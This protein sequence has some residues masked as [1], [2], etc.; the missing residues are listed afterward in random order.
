MKRPN[1][2]Q[3]IKT[4]TASLAGLLGATF[5]KQGRGQALKSK[6]V[7]VTDGKA[8]TG[9][10]WDNQALEQQV[11]TNML[12]R[13][14]INL[15]SAKDSMTALKSLIPNLSSSSRIAI[16]VNC[17]N[18][19]LPSQPKVVL[20]L[21]DLLAEAGA[22]INNIVIYDR[23]DAELVACGYKLNT[24]SEG[25]KCYSSQNKA[26]GYDDLLTR[27]SGAE[28]RLSKITSQQAEHIINVAVL[29]NH[30][31]AGVSL[32]LKN[33]FGSID[34]PEYL[35]GSDRNCSPEIARL[36]ANQ[37]IHGKTRLVLIDAMF[38]TYK[39]G[40]AAKPDFAPMTLIAA[41]DP[42]AAD[43]VGQEMINLRR[44]QDKLEPII[45]EHIVA[46]Q[47]LG[48]GTGQSSQIDKIELRLDPVTEKPKPWLKESSGCQTI[49]G[50]NQ[51]LV[52]TAAALGAIKARYNPRNL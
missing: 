34:R 18:S 2:R 39:S 45:A 3:F 42:V 44:Q 51:N 8:W 1:R 33:H 48:L 24:S 32:T 17:V 27:V 4:L 25:I 47:K 49:E 23:S 38:A 5:F 29:K 43:S 9:D 10:S 52:L 37:N 28:V 16:K 30:Q 22:N 50:H 14:L 35:H 6:V 7:C 40:L 26:G 31:M 21:I 12:D 41:T 46:A 15:T 19:D 13:A 11:I 36:Y 20:G